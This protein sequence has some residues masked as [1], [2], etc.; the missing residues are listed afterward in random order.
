MSSR[1]S[2]A[3]DVRRASE[4]ESIQD[5]G[6]RDTLE[7][8]ESDIDA[9]GEPDTEMHEDDGQDTFQVIHDLSTYLCSVEEE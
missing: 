2:G 5:V 9:E 8:E 3:S 7:A 1:R 4:V 6:M